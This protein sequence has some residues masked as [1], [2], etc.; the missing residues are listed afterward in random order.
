VLE[1]AVATRREIQACQDALAPYRLRLI[2]LAPPAE[3]SDQRDAQ[4][5]GKH[6]ARYFRH[7]APLLATELAGAGRWIDNS[8]QSPLDTVRVILSGRDG[9]G[10]GS[11]PGGQRQEPGRSPGQP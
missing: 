11:G 10:E 6:V 4:R 5:S 2:V 3:I 1:G 9:A 7:L 8:G